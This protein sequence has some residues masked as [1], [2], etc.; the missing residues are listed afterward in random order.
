MNI[1]Q[2]NLRRLLMRLRAEADNAVNADDRQALRRVA[3]LLD[4]ETITVD[5]AQ[6]LIAG[7]REGDTAR[8][9]ALWIIEL[10][11]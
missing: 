2:P 11:R 10:I 4:A 3:D 1:S 7:I 9:L 6:A 5:Q 8:K